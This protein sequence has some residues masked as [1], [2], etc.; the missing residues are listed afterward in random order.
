MEGAES[1]YFEDPYHDDVGKALKAFVGAKTRKENHFAM[2]NL[3]ACLRWY[4]YRFNDG[5]RYRYG[6]GQVG[7][8]YIIK[9]GPKKLGLLS[10]YRNRYV[11]IVCTHSRGWTVHQWFGTV[12]LTA[13]EANALV[14]ATKLCFYP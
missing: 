10:K 13:E 6:L 1:Q 12:K 9:V 14:P 7:K 2:S 4:R 3:V 11:R 5:K 8:S